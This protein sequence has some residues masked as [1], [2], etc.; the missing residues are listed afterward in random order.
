M[1][2]SWDEDGDGSITRNEFCI[3]MTMMGC[4]FGTP[5]LLAAFD[6]FEKEKSGKIRLAELQTQLS[7]FYKVAAPP[8]SLHQPST[9]LLPNSP[10]S[11]PPH[12]QPPIST[13]LPLPTS[14]IPPPS[15]HIPP[16]SSQLLLRLFSASML[17]PLS[18][19]S[20]SRVPPSATA[21]PLPTKVERCLERVIDD[22][23]M[24][25]ELYLAWD[26]A[27]G[28]TGPSSMEF[29]E[30]CCRAGLEADGRV[31]DRLFS[32]LD[33]DKSGHLS[34]EELVRLVRW[35]Q[36]SLAATKLSSQAMQVWASPAPSLRT[37]CPPS[38]PTRS[39]PI[40]LA[41]PS[42]PT[43]GLSLMP[44]LPKRPYECIIIH[45]L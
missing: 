8:S 27:E 3:G 16:P 44:P 17:H 18:L 1:F 34:R 45:T 20:T 29:K 22:V 42:L 41:K 36:S 7:L 33:I 23:R 14:H 11:S 30:A 28:R 5:Y 37:R 15:F 35:L 38:L 13:L 2:S 9:T 21:P 19:P 4:K 24:R 26:T 32:M 40:S 10:A 31:L 12:Q 43:Q 39:P 6:S 25:E